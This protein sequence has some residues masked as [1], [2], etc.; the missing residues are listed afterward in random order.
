M[1]KKMLIVLF[2]IFILTGCK[3]IEFD[4]KTSII[5]WTFQTNGKKVEKSE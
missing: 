1:Y 5:K 3:N 4:P 2:M